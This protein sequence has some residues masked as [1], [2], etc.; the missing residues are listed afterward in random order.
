MRIAIV[1]ETFVPATDGICTRFAKM[2]VELKKLGHEV[3]VI[4]PDLGIDEY[5]GIPVFRMDTLTFPLYGSR[6]WG[7]PSRK[8]KYILKAFKPDIVH[9]VN[10][11]FMGTSAV[12]YA[13][14]L[15]LPLITS[16][17]THMPNY[18]DHY[19]M[20]LLKPLLWEYIRF[21][22]QPSDINITVSQTLLEE[23]NQQ[24]I[25]TVGVLPSGID[26]D[27]RHPKYFDQALYDQLTFNQTD[28]KLLVY[29]GRLAAEKD[30]DQLRVIFDHRD[31]ICLV[32]VGDGP[33]RENLEALFEGT[34]TTFLGFLHGE[35]LSKAF[36]TGDAFIFPSISET[37][38]LVISEAMAS[39]LP[40]FAAKNGPTLEQ[41]TDKETGFI[42]ESRNTESLMT[43]LKQLDNPL[44]LEKVRI[45]ALKQ[46]ESHSWNNATRSLLDYY[47]LT[48]EA[49]QRNQSIALQETI[50]F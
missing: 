23:L 31:D 15:N 26:L 10:P 42:F 1:T 44:L 40:V 12:R 4:S 6:P 14:Q 46:A 41:I 22:Y 35:E 47:D 50:N 21:W 29:V 16:Y 48:L 11:F 7:V 45:A 36:A 33:E 38:G 20:P 24:N 28:K 2:V 5:E 18:L 9:A 37:Y 34:P 30:L 39:G 49:Y 32:I 25:E 17:H 27:N 19:K 8:I 43:A 3:I 13:K